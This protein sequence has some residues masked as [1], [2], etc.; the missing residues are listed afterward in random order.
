MAEAKWSLG[1]ET[2]KYIIVEAGESW[3]R[4][5]FDVEWN[6]FVAWVTARSYVDLIEE[7]RLKL[8]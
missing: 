4:N 2:D 8:S 3:E 1:E 6:G 5:W 7:T